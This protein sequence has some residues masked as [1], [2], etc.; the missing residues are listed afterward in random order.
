MGRSKRSKRIRKHKKKNQKMTAPEDKTCL[1]AIYDTFREEGD[2]NGKFLKRNPTLLG[3]YYSEPIYNLYKI[4][5]DAAVLEGGYTSVLIEVYEIPEKELLNL[6]G[7]YGY[8]E[9]M[10]SDDPK[11]DIYNY[12]T[13][14]KVRTPYGMA[15]LYFYN[16]NSNAN[17]SDL[18]KIKSGDWVDFESSV[19]VNKLIKL[20][21]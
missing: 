11:K 17:T 10:K 8:E 16:I 5:N 9:A 6:D 19:Q 14:K 4:H 13:R 12:F 15:Y 7:D 3:T 1:V 20:N 18:V 2:N 21:T